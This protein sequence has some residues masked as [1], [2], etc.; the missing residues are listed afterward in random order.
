MKAALGWIVGLAASLGAHAGM[1]AFLAFATEPEP[2]E[3]E[4]QQSGRIKMTSYEVPQ[5]KA[6][7]QETKGE[8]QSAESAEGQALGQGP[9][10]TETASAQP[11]D[12]P[13]Q[14]PL[15]ATGTRPAPLKPDNTEVAE[16]QN[17]SVVQAS[18]ASGA[19]TPALRAE[20]AKAKA[21]P[22]ASEAL[23]PQAPP[24]AAQDTALPSERPVAILPKAQ[25]L[26]SANASA[27]TPVAVSQ[28]AATPSP[29]SPLL[30]TVL[31]SAT[32]TAE[33]V[34]PTA[35]NAGSVPASSLI[36]EASNQISPDTPPAEAKAPPAAAAPSL[37][38]A[39][40]AAPAA[41]LDA[42]VVTAATGWAGDS[43]VPFDPVS[44]S[45][46]QSFMRPLD[47]AANADGSARDGIS[48]ILS[49]VP[50][51]RLA[52][53]FIPETGTLELRGH[54]PDAA[55]RE[56]L[57]NAIR[58]QLGESIP[59]GGSMLVLPSPQ[60]DVLSRLENLGLPQS[61]GQTRDSMQVG[62][63]TQI[64]TFDYGEDERVIV[65]MRSPDYPAYVYVD[66]FDVDGRVLHLR[67]NQWEDVELHH[68]DSPIEIGADRE[69]KSSVKL[70]VSPP[71]GQELAIAYASSLPLYEGLRE[72]IEPAEP[73]LDYMRNRIAELKSEN[74][75]Y[76]G[77]W[78]YMFIQ[79]HP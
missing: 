68:S 48:E 55:L 47:T 50:C 70:V 69:G 41:P 61:Q 29:S 31:A 43:S 15:A 44:L 33:P 35:P 21:N 1:F 2:L 5:S 23:A 36:S 79:T 52:A 16:I 46:V 4:P 9:V 73:Y 22:V 27:T 3:A 57:L 17:D 26:Q 12:Q 20:G 51:S 60:C 28:P 37:P 6:T 53:T 62:A 67:P 66:F 14:A 18:T 65:K 11:L 59:V 74:P 24:P 76:K 49:A 19:P 54:V 13:V 8:E 39:A 32:A 63:I 71:F 25:P 34:G 45:A 40:S 10:R 30:N 7:P 38:P 64:S 56:P 42:P 78:V 77:E 72:T 58:N 75:D